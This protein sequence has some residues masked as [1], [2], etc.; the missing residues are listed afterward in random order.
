MVSMVTDPLIL[1]GAHAHLAPEQII[2][3]ALWR[4]SCANLLLPSLSSSLFP[5]LSPTFFLISHVN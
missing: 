1:G 3:C 4:E 2:V 5:A